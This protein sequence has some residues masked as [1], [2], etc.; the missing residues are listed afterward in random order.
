NS[1]RYFNGEYI[2]NLRGTISSLLPSK[3]NL[4]SYRHHHREGLAYVGSIDCGLSM[5]FMRDQYVLV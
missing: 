5:V 1:S 3:I 4:E 2:P